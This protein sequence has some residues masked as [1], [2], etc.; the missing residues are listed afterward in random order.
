MAGKWIDIA[1]PRHWIAVLA[2]V[3]ALALPAGGALANADG[4]AD[5]E[6]E[7]NWA[8]QTVLRTQI[9]L[10][11]VLIVN[12]ELALPIMRTSAA[13]TVAHL[14]EKLAQLQRREQTLI[15]Q[16]HARFLLTWMRTNPVGFQYAMTSVVNM[17]MFGLLTNIDWSRA[18]PFAVTTLYSFYALAFL[19]FSQAMFMEWW[20]YNKFHI[21]EEMGINPEIDRAGNVQAGPLTPAQLFGGLRNGD[22]DTVTLVRNGETVVLGGI[23]VLKESETERQLPYLSDIPYTSRLFKNVGI[24]RR[25]RNLMILVSPRIVIQ[26][27]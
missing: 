14:Q 27:E 4:G 26:E 8:R 3:L 5:D 12:N 20:N 24:A 13:I 1:G 11:K 10:A 16:T 2:L 21:L 15:A 6:A 23:R 22:Y 19:N 9:E 17:M 25:D 7:Q 18:D